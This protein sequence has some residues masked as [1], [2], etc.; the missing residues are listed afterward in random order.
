MIITKYWED[1]DVGYKFVTPSITV[2]E[3]HL[4]NWAGLTMDFYEIHMDKEYAATTA[5][6]QRVVH[7]PLIFAM[8]IGLVHQAQVV[9]GAVKAWLGSDIKMLAPVF[10]GDTIRNEVEVIARS[11][12]KKSSQGVQTW[13]YTVVNQRSEPV[14]KA[15]TKFMMH[16]RPQA[17]VL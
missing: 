16:R 1:F 12:T 7:G 13:Q 10:I 6:G 5:F 14:L 15:D 3:A 2:T 11:E 17:G 9:G 4:V 8:A